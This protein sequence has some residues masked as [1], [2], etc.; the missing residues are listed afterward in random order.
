MSQKQRFLDLALRC[1]RLAEQLSDRSS[2]EL[3]REAAG[4]WRLLADTDELLSPGRW[5]G[6]RS[7]PARERRRDTP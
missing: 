4:N 1:E 5:S 7:G 3:L 6:R 2:R